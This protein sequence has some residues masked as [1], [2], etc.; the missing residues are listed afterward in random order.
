[1]IL[2]TFTQSV[3]DFLLLHGFDGLDYDW[4]YPAAYPGGQPE[5]KVYSKS[6]NID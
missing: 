2:K 5:D 6:H 3:V 4:E 1:M